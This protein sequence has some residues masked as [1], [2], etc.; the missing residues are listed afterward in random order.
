MKKE[1]HLTQSGIDKLEQELEELKAK[2]VEVAE[3][4]R[5]AREHGD[6]SENAEYHNARDEQG[7]LEARISEVEHILR[8]TE[9]IAEPKNP[10]VVGLGNTVLLKGAKGESSYTVVGSV[11]ANPAQNKISDQSPI[12]KELIGKKVKDTIVINLPAGSQ[13]YTIKSIK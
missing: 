10:G 13:T 3:K 8:N 1:F 11:E 12:G 6:L 4:L 9:L 5:I 2:R 7:Q